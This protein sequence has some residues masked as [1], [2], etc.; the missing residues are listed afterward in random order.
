MPTESVQQI[1][2][3][4]T[5]IENLVRASIV[6]SQPVSSIV[7]APVQPLPI[8]NSKTLQSPVTNTTSTTDVVNTVPKPMPPVEPTND[9]NF[10][11]LIIKQCRQNRLLEQVIAAINM[12]N[13][14]LTQ[15]VQR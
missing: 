11:T 14:L 12:I 6:N 2:T 5:A 3:T 10:L 8:A 1:A 9:D 13:A 7:N 4:V 15:L